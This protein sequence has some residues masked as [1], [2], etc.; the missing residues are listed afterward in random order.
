[1]LIA[2]RAHARHQGGLW[3]FPGGKL[4]AGEDA[5]AGLRREL[6]EELGLHLEAA[7]PLIRVD[8]AYPDRHVLLDVWKVTRWRGRAR[9]CEG[10]P[11]RWVEIEALRA[12]ALP[13]ADV[14]I[15]TALELPPLYL[16][17]PEPADFGPRFQTVLE[18]ALAAGV[19]LVQLRARRLAPDALAR[20]AA[21]C[22]A[23]CERYGARLLVN[24]P[25]E[26]AL[27]LGAHGA[28]LSSAVLAALPGRDWSDDLLVGASCH[29]RAEIGHARRLGVDFIAVAPVLATA[30]H[31][32]VR[33]LGWDALERL[34]RLANR[35]V[36]A[37]GGM[38]PAHM[39]EAWRR[40]AQGLAMISAVWSARSP[41]H[42]VR[43]CLE[44][45]QAAA[46][47]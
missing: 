26:V 6:R 16:I 46:A 33:P 3:E 13:E 11:L 19:R 12:C 23:L 18:Q 45:E 27:R 25:P 34:A 28:H 22:V 43:R 29:N 2:R 4:E 9:G 32:R 42:A 36:Y 47:G 31:P 30:S 10:Q 21:R 20:T 5:L 24:A 7:R 39:G 17:S 37:L 15:V 8:H 44:E 41:A 40:G 1:V 14:P 38:G 35:P